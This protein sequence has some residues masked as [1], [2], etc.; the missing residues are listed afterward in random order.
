[1]DKI[2]HYQFCHLGYL[3]K[4]AE[5]GQLWRFRKLITEEFLYQY[6][7]NADVDSFKEHLHT[8]GLNI[9]YSGIN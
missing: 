6:V 8:F 2:E 4:T 9:F 5:D 3:S 1:M 7:F